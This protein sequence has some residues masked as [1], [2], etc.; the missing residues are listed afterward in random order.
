MEMPRS[1]SQER[2]S[3]PK[4]QG[5]GGQRLPAAASAC[6]LRPGWAPAWRTLS[7]WTLSM[8]RNGGMS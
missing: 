8:P 7:L 4:G 5:L 3:A 1:L 2:A 6:L